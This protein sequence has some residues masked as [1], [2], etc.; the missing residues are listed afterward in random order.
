MNASSSALIVAALASF[1]AGCATTPI[2]PLVS[3]HDVLAVLPA[4]NVVVE[5]FTVATSEPQR[6]GAYE[7]GW[8]PV[9]SNFTTPM[10]ADAILGDLKASIRADGSSQQGV[11]LTLLD[12]RLYVEKRTADAIPFVGLVSALSERQIKCRVILNVQFGD[13]SKKMTLE[14]FEVSPLDIVD[15][16]PAAA[17]NLVDSCKTKLVEGIARAATELT[18]L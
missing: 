11:R 9:R 2:G 14:A 1:L 5:D 16:Q 18:K 3:S 13:T 7:S 17:L 15:L 10:L 6:L 4:R 12:A 8:Q